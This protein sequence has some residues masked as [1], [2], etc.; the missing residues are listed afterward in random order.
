MR[1]WLIAAGALLIGLGA[2]FFV[3][4]EFPSTG[5]PDNAGR[6]A[7]DNGD[8]ARSGDR[9]DLDAFMRAAEDGQVS[10]VEQLLKQGINVNDKDSQGETALMHAAA[11]AQLGVLKTLLDH[12]A[13]MAEK[14]KKG[15]TAVIKAAINAHLPVLVMLK[16]R[17]SEAVQSNTVYQLLALRDHEGRSGFMYAAMA[18]QSEIADFLE[19]VSVSAMPVFLA[20]L[21]VVVLSLDVSFAAAAASAFADGVTVM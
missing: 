11:K 7:P 19:R 18:G 17:H 1:T 6:P 10:R 13:L 4:R 3:G 8:P 9:P 14:D 20:A 5:R 15:Q 12:N 2:G 21:S 16:G